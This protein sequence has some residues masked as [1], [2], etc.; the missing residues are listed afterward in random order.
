MWS[1]V[2]K[3]FRGLEEVEGLGDRAWG[4]LRATA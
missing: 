1:S 4:P 3:Q 2:Y